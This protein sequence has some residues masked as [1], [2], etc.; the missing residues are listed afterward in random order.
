MCLKV[1]EFYFW[2]N[3]QRTMAGITCANPWKRSH[4]PL[5]SSNRADKVFWGKIQIG[6]FVTN[7]M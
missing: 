2:V 5:K 1:A 6:R 4:T 3:L 7:L